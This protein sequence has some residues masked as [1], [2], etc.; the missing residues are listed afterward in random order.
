MVKYSCE[1]QLDDSFQLK[2]FLCSFLFNHVSMMVNNFITETGPFVIAD[3]V[4]QLIRM[5]LED[6]NVTIVGKNFSY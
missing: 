1:E 6:I 4:S 2:H 3:W 5:N